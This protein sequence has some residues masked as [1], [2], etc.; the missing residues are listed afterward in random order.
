M[1]SRALGTSDLR[2]SLVGLGCNNFGGRIDLAATRR[3]VDK[4]IE[5]G[6][7]LFDTADVYGNKGG[8]ETCLGEV[9]GAR[10]KKIVLATKFGLPI[11]E[12]GTMKGA[13]AARARSG[14]RHS[15]PVASITGCSPSSRDSRVAWSTSSVLDGSKSTGMR[16]FVAACKASSEVSNA[17]RGRSC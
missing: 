6:I 10:R 5:L 1:E 2:V 14:R 13:A 11:D 4:A 9:L 17:G 8:S 3:V 15:W 16:L 12:S 7:T